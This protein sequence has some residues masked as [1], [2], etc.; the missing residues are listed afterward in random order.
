VSAT[1]QAALAPHKRGRPAI[2]RDP[3][4]LRALLE[5][6]R[7]AE[8]VVPDPE[9]HGTRA[10]LGMQEQEAVVGAFDAQREQGARAKQ[11]V[12]ALEL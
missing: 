11:A 5:T 7:P 4:A 1:P 9:S 3:K 10:A 6:D 12:A 2:T 8:L